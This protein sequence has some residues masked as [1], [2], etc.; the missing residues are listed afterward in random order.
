MEKTLKIL[1]TEEQNSFGRNCTQALKNR[2]YDVKLA[3]KNGSEVL[4]LVQSEQ[5]DHAVAE[6][7]AEKTPGGHG[8]LGRRQSAF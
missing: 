2:G 4:R 1:F 7:S 6:K 8:D 5:P 3:S